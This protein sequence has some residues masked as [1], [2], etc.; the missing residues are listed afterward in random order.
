M[1]IN[2]KISAIFA[3]GLL[4]CANSASATTLTIATVDNNDMIVMQKLSSAFTAANPGIDLKWVVLDE[5]ELR[6][7]VT[8]DIATKRGEFD[9]M[10][11]GAYEAPIWAKQKWLLSFDNLPADYDVNDLLKPVRDGLSFEG[12]LYALPFYAESSMT[13]YNTELFKKAGLQMP[14][15]PTYAQVAEFAQK[16]HDPAN[17]VYGVCLRGL[18]GWGENVAYVTTVVNTFGG[19]W[20]DPEWNA[21]L[22]EPAWAEGVK[23]YTSLLGKYGP[24]N[25]EKNGF[26]QNLKLFSEGHCGMWIDATVAASILFDPNQSKVAGKT[27][28]APAPIASHPKGSN[29]LWSWALAV[30]ASSKNADAAQHFIQWATSKSYIE[31][32][33]KEKGWVAVPPG[34]RASTYAHPE[35]QKAAP[36]SASVLDAIKSADPV[37]TTAKPKPYN[38][39]QYVGIP[40][41]QA[42]GTRV[43][44]LIAASL[45]G[46]KSVEDALTEAQTT[47]DRTM[48][49]AGYHK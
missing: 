35:Y 13:F 1:H 27:G 7:R 9:V 42:L 40:E 3:T 34:T 49:Q 30:P 14:Q 21:T 5:N 31:L 29:W 4:A 44:Q 8:T 11:I 20:F 33:G 18:P 19:R 17:N 37:T 47:A 36:F 39:V 15:Q 46:Q 16:I 10:T 12:K 23:F 2:S 26:T 28:L 24:P 38:G 41:F 43:G 45:T 25:P 48:R 6:Q 22:N 32:V